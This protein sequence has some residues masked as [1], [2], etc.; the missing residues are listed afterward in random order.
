[1]YS[2]RLAVFNM[3]IVVEHDVSIVMN[4]AVFST[5]EEVHSLV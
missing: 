5:D 1:M 2:T 3:H 4:D